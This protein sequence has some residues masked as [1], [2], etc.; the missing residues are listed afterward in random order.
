MEP[1]PSR[2]IPDGQIAA[3]IGDRTGASIIA[4][5]YG[6]IPPNW[7]GGE[8]MTWTAAGKPFPWIAQMKAR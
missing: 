6:E 8:G 5:T 3:E 2:G 7:K 1:T 4:S